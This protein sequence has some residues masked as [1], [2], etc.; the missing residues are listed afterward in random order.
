LK[1]KFLWANWDIDELKVKAKEIEGG[2]LSIGLGGW[3]FQAANWS[4]TWNT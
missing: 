4:A 3:P 1:S 2:L